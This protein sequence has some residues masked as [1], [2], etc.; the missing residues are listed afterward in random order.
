[1]ELPIW[2]ISALLLFGAL[3]LLGYL[4]LRFLDA[5]GLDAWQQGEDRLPPEEDQS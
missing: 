3:A 2:L 1:M 5:L 4:S